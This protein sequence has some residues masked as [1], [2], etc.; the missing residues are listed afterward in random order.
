[1]A[2]R[3]QCGAC[4]QPIEIDD[5]WA[6]RTVACPYCRNTITAPAESTLGDL[7]AVPSASPI[8]AGAF[9]P[10]PPVSSNPFAVA[11][12]ALACLVLALMVSSYALASAHSLELEQFAKDIQE[13]QKQDGSSWGA[14][15][16]YAERHNGKIPPWFVAMGLMQMAAILTSLGSVICGII[17]LRIAHRRGLA[18]SALC[19]SGGAFIFLCAGL[20]LGM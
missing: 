3:F 2:I 7:D 16:R 6:S 18:I 5:E 11:A 4:S 12:F 10:P 17:G 9:P 20:V 15:T 1:M 14:M 19:I 8:G 13:A